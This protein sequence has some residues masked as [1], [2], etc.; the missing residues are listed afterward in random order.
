MG[1]I[2]P[3]TGAV[4]LPQARSVAERLRRSQADVKNLS[5][6]EVEEAAI[7]SP[8]ALVSISDEHGQQSPGKRERKKEDAKRV[9]EDAEEPTHL[10]VS[11]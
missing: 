5:E 9:D 7:E 8:D 11:A 10:D 4:S 6:S 3:F 2:N 1:Q